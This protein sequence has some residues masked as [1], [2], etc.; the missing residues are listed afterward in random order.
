MGDW[1]RQFIMHLTHANLRESMGKP[2]SCMQFIK[3]RIFFCKSH[4]NP[5]QYYESHENLYQ[6]LQVMRTASRCAMK[7]KVHMIKSLSP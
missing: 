5:Y 3:S 6:V 2:C 7:S 1:I 4:E